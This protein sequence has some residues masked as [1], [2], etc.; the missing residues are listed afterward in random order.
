[1]QARMRCVLALWLVA[2]DEPRRGTVE[3][4][5]DGSV[6]DARIGDA[7]AVDAQVADAQVVDAQVVDSSGPDAQSVDAGGADPQ[8]D[9][10]LADGAASTTEAGVTDAGE[11]GGGAS[12]DADAGEPPPHE[13]PCEPA[14]EAISFV[15]SSVGS[16]ATFCLAS[17]A[18]MYLAALPSAAGT[19]ITVTQ[20][21]PAA[22]PWPNPSFAGA[23]RDVIALGPEGL[24]LPEPLAMYLPR[25]SILAFAFYGD[26]ASPTPLR[27]PTYGQV[28]QLTRLGLVGIV[29]AQTSCETAAGA[30]FTS[31]WVDV[32]GQE[33]MC[34]SYRDG[35]TTYRSYS[36]SSAPFCFD[37]RAWCCVRPGTA[38]GGCGVDNIRNV[39]YG[40]TTSER[41]YCQDVP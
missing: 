37:V 3:L 7:R 9:A 4:D 6:V 34:S 38:T 33:G 39:N 16:T 22:Q 13:P 15:V 36:C 35:S 28:P 24:A 30:P 41:A 17:G 23:F 26:R 31:G 32:P 12:V 20:V 19:T 2:C 18:R 1:M 25:G 40:R 14:D 8:R 11:D 29:G 10:E 21:D 5:A 27:L